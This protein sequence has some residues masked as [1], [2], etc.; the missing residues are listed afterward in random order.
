MSLSALLAL[1]SLSIFSTVGMC[2]FQE[3]GNG[4][5]ERE[6]L[7]T[8]YI[9]LLVLIVIILALESLF[10][11][12]FF[13]NSQGRPI[14]HLNISSIYPH[15]ELETNSSCQMSCVGTALSLAH[16]NQK[17]SMIL[18]IIFLSFSSGAKCQCI[19]QGTITTLFSKFPLIMHLYKDKE[20]HNHTTTW[21]VGLLPTC[22]SRFDS[23]NQTTR[24]YFLVPAWMACLSLTELRKGL[25]EV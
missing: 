10:K 15:R 18:V 5:K 21:L 1:K 20:E 11:V 3:R 13:F 23:W 2:Y 16:P 24:K 9:H 22:W 17:T 12:P 19:H 4:K 25:V 6:D 14:Q 8:Q 7:K